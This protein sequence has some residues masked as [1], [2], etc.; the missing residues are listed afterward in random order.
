[1]GSGKKNLL[2]VSNSFLTRY[3]HG[4]TFKQVQPCKMSLWRLSKFHSRLCV[5]ATVSVIKTSLGMS[6][7]S[8]FHLQPPMTTS[9]KLL[10]SN[11]EIANRM[12]CIQVFCFV[13]RFVYS[14]CGLTSRHLPFRA[15]HGF[16]FKEMFK[17]C[18]RNYGE[19]F[20]GI[21]GGICF[22]TK[23]SVMFFL[24]STGVRNINDGRC[25]CFY[26]Y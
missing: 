11:K 7:K 14:G 6:S 15:C 9:L 5:V 13:Q 21:K 17:N 19:A 25:R 23:K 12:V 4:H 1:M 2:S 24:V 16:F 22:P 8:L 3:L 26:C 18:N 10:Y 20:N